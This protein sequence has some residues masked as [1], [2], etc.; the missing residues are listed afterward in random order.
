MGGTGGVF[1]GHRN[2]LRVGW[3]ENVAHAIAMAKGSFQW[4]RE[5]LT[6]EQY[7]TLRNGG[8]PVQELER[9]GSFLWRRY[10]YGYGERKVTPQDLQKQIVKIFRKDGPIP[11]AVNL[12]GWSRGGVSCHMMAH[13]M[14]HDPELKNFRTHFGTQ[15]CAGRNFQPSY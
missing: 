5:D 8:V 13:A 3:E 2:R 1:V 12:V 10:G 7:D 4:K 6:K 9:V 11:T 14:A 15:S